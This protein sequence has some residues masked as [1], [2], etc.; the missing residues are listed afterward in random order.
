M[1]FSGPCDFVQKEL[2]FSP[3]KLVMQNDG[4]LVIQ[5]GI[6]QWSTNTTSPGAYFI[7][8]DDGSLVV[9]SYAG[10]PLKIIYNP[11]DQ[12]SPF[13]PGRPFPPGRPP[14]Q[15]P[16]NNDAEYKRLSVDN[17]WLKIKL[18]QTFFVDYERTKR[19]KHM[20]LYSAITG[21]LIWRKRCR[22]ANA[23]TDVYLYRWSTCVTLIGSVAPK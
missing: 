1:S 19:M 11:L 18:L 20:I 6:L 4:N 10:K 17:D 7:L 21:H 23:E 8:Q 12:F 13:E 9:Y 16:W 15:Y 2:S 3:T 5:D 22:S 14:Y